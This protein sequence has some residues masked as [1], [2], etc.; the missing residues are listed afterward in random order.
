MSEVISVENHQQSA[1]DHADERAGLTT[2][3]A[4]ALYAT[5][6]IIH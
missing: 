4:E 1:K 2:A 5:V 6:R 3:E